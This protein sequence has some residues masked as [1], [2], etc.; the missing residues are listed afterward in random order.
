MKYLLKALLV[1][2]VL[3]LFSGCSDVFLQ[4]DVFETTSNGVTNDFGET[5]TDNSGE[6]SISE[7]TSLWKDGFE[8]Y[9]RYIDYTRM[10]YVFVDNPIDRYWLPRLHRY[11]T[12]L[13]LRKIQDDYLAAWQ[14]EFEN[15]L[16]YV[17]EFT[18]YEIPIDTIDAYRK[19]VELQGS[20]L[21]SMLVPENGLGNGGRSWI[22]E[23]KA[24][25]YKT[26]ALTLVSQAISDNA[27]DSN[28]PIYRSCAYEWLDHDYYHEATTSTV[29]TTKP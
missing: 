12:N 15:A 3:L 23:E 14:E 28:T 22:N 19:S 21:Q 11:E 13:E 18:E 4:K 5:P 2:L 27:L 25:I 7:A 26:A 1:I 20:L 24:R 8:E 16:K 6:T 10:T 9:I 17:E 29:S